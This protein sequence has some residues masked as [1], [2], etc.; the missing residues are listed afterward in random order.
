MLLNSNSEIRVHDPETLKLTDS[1]E[2]KSSIIDSFPLER[3]FSLESKVFLA[4]ANFNLL[5][6]SKNLKKVQYMIDLKELNSLMIGREILS[7]GKKEKTDFR[8]GELGLC[9]YSLSTMKNKFEQQSLNVQLSVLK[10]YLI[11]Q[12][13]KKKTFENQVQLL[14]DLLKNLALKGTFL[15]NPKL[16]SMFS[17]FIRSTNNFTVA[18]FN[19]FFVNKFSVKQISLSF[20]SMDDQ[21]SD[22]TRAETIN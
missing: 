6:F 16:K 17:G 2:V 12:T 13:M 20:K 11:K 22:E 19:K 21:A 10:H 4:K 5:V 1:F 18:K 15:K 8:F 3:I 9:E 14:K 7:C